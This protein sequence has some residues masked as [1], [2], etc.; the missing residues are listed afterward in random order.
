[1]RSKGTSEQLAQIRGRGLSLLGAGK[2]PK[3]VAEI[4]KVTPRCVY[5]WY[6][7]AKSP[8]RKKAVRSPGRP[9][10]LDAKQIKRLEKALDQG[11][12][13]HGYAGDYW[14]LERIA[15]TIW[16]MFGVRYQPS[17]VWYVMGRMG[18]S[19]QKPQ[20]RALHRNEEAIE[21]WKK[22]V[23]PEIKKSA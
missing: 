19:S 21:V 6:Q 13:K 9:R 17:G 15:Q 4:L 20:R 10:K 16:Q 12:Y 11:A 5:R 3:E 22:E 1:M 23:L 8:K 14:T 7:E 18:W 2:K